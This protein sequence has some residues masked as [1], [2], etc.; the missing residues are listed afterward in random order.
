MAWWHAPH[1]RAE[2]NLPVASFA[3]TAT[4][5]ALRGGSGSS[6]AGADSGSRKAGGSST[7]ASAPVSTMRR[8]L[9]ARTDT[10]SGKARSH[11][12]EIGRLLGK[13]PMV[14]PGFVEATQSNPRAGSAR[15]AI[16]STMAMFPAWPG[17]GPRR[18]LTTCQAGWQTGGR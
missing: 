15:G 10:A 13:S 18:R 16:S 9:Q 12:A 11:P 7:R 14:H 4:G 17:T 8:W 3:G 5:A 6:Q 1:S 2:L